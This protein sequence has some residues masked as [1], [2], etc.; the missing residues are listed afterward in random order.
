MRKVLLISNYVFH[1]RQKVYNYFT[2]RFKQDGYEFHVLSNE[3]QNAG[4][5]FKFTA[6]TL[7]MSVKAYERVIR[8]IKPAVVIVFLHLK[9]KIQIPIIHYCKRKKISVVFWNK[10]VSDQD[11]HNPVKNM[12]YH[13][14]HNCCDALITYT[15]E[16][17]GNFQ[18]KNRHKLFIAYNTV[19]CSDIDR[20]KYDKQAI[21]KKYGIKEKK[22]VLYISRLKKN[23]RI[24]ILLNALANVPDVAV[25]VMGAGI[26]PVL[27]EMFD[28]VSNLYYMGTKYGEEGTEIWAMGDIFSIPVNVGL[29]INEAIFW[30]MP[31]VTMQGFQ[32]PEIYYLKEGKT[33]FIAKNEEDYKQKLL[34]LLQ[35][36]DVLQ[37]I[38]K[39]CQK[40]YEEE[41]A[42][43]KMY[44]GFIS[45][46]QY[47]RGI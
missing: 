23:K 45:A 14:I 29:G 25:V 20:S 38:R 17:T 5:D 34:Y 30:N 43:D 46:I 1:Y 21:R 24:E 40:E 35:N 47:C 15:P 32:P 10:G 8:E 27:K 3:F 7:P 33:G 42:I 11:P 31:V 12:L 41:V 4:Y 9:D 26:T 39:E 13:H 28:S 44:Q 6:H 2:D 37:K 36:D 22:V 16:M 19:D 18:K